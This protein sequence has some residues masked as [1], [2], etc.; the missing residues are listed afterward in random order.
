MTQTQSQAGETQSPYKISREA[1]K[2]SLHNSR[3][4]LTHH[5]Q[6]KHKPFCQKHRHTHTHR[7]S[8]KLSD[9]QTPTHTD[10]HA[11][12]L[13][14][15]PVWRMTQGPPSH[16]VHVRVHRAAN[17]DSVP[18]MELTVLLSHARSR[19]RSAKLSPGTP[20][21]RCPFN[22][23]PFHTGGVVLCATRCSPV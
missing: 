7:V 22:S 6:T 13:Y 18:I 8:E 19:A 4:P 9:R 2:F 10:T 20:N 14:R 23:H 11:R 1:G 21:V 17:I 3:N 12:P 15:S 5:D 16:R